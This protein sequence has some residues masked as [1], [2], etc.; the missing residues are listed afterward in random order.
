VRIELLLNDGLRPR[1]LAGWLMLGVKLY[2]A[3]FTDADDG[4]IFDSFYYPKIALGHGHSF[5]YF[6]PEGRI[7]AAPLR[8][9]WQ[10]RDARKYCVTDGLSS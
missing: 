6:G 9:G 4:N 8:S 1:L 10:W 2:L 5:P 7:S 3:E